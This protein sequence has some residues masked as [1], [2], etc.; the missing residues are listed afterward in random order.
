MRLMSHALAGILFAVG[1]VISGMTQPSKVIGFLDVFGNWDPSLA[2]VMAGAI[3]VNFLGYRAV[4]KLRTP[5]FCAEYFVPTSRKIDTKLI[6]GA[7]LF[8]AGWGLAGYC[9]GPAIVSL[10]HFNQSTLLFVGSMLT[11]MLVYG[12]VSRYQ[13]RMPA[14]SEMTAQ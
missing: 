3:S 10:A 13:K 7:A 9:P 2:F 5:V 1:L 4:K 14:R 12:A 11:S 6:G 8:G